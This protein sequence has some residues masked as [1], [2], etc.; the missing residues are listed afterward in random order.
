MSQKNIMIA[1]QELESRNRNNNS[2]PLWNLIDIFS[3]QS[4]IIFNML[5]YIHKKDKIGVCLF[6]G[7]SEMNRF[8]AM[9][10][11]GIIFIVYIN[12]P[13]LLR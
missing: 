8:I 10:R 9:Q 12:A 13:G 1:P 11:I 2:C 6:D 4:N 7:A 5:Q 3:Y